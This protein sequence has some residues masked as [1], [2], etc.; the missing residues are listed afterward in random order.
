MIRIIHGLKKENHIN[1]SKVRKSINMFSVNQMAMY[2]T[3][4]EG[5]NVL[6][7]LA[8]EEIRSKW[9]DKSEKKYCLRNISKNDLKV[10]DRP[11]SNCLGFTYTH[12]KLYNILPNHIRES[13]NQNI[14]K[15]E[16]KKWIWE[17]I[18]SY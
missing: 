15:S 18:P 17:T 16:I 11:K 12:A 8:S 9:T 5:Y 10:P 14:F 4:L 3:L 7:N 13:T 6:K 1:L 2:H